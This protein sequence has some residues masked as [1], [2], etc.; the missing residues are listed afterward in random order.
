[1]LPDINIQMS[2]SQVSDL[3]FNHENPNYNA[4]YNAADAS[5]SH[6]EVEEAVL[7]DAEAFVHDFSI[8]IAAAVLAADFL[9]RR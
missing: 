2:G 6:E 5:P 3:F 9:A 4:L 1:M 7:A 8:P